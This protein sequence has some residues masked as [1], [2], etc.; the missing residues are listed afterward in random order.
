M[1]KLYEMSWKKAK[2]AFQKTSTA[3]FP[4]GSNEQHGPHLPLGTDWIIANEIATRLSEKTN[5]L[6]FPVFP[7]GYAEYHMDFPG[8]MYLDKETL[9]IVLMDLCRCLNKWGIKRIL[10][11]NGHG[12]NMDTLHTVGIKIRKKY[13]MLAAAGQ[14]WEMLPPKIKGDITESHGGTVETAMVRAIN[15]NIVDMD[16]AFLAKVKPLTKK[17]ET[18]SIVHSKFEGGL[19]RIFLRVGDVSEHGSMTEIEGATE[20]KDYSAATPELGRELLDKVI[21]QLADFI[22]EFE[23][24][25]LPKPQEEP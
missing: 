20:V 19:I 2:I 9:R 6:V 23:K 5:A 15:P 17:I 21:N 12:G 13:G 4:I 3:I 16:V 10:F 14:W 7:Y 24:I 18:V 1:A 8:T 22:P 25:E 11:V